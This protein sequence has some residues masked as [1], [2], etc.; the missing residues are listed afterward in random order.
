MSA[1]IKTELHI[2][3]YR[4]G[5]DSANYV[6]KYSG[7]A[8]HGR[9]HAEARRGGLVG[10]VALDHRC[11]TNGSSAQRDVTITLRDEAS[12]PG[13]GL[14]AL[15]RNAQGL[16]RPDAERQRRGRRCD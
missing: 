9:C 8:Y 14:Q 6:H 16:H 7:H 15:Q 5:N 11:R 3:E 13:A 10:S 2:S 12:N 1:G 4:D